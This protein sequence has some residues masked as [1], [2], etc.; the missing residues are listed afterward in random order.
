M[1]IKKAKIKNSPEAMRGYQTSDLI[2]DGKLVFTVWG[3]INKDLVTAI[4]R[5]CGIDLKFEK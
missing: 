1:K 3:S 2:V 4:Y 5:D